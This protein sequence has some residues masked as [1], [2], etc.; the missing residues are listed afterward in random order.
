MTTMQKIIKYLALAFAIFLCVNIIGGICGALFSFSFFFGGRDVAGEMQEYYIEDNIDILKVDLSAIDFHIKSGDKFKLETN[1]KYINYNTN[2]NVL[3]IEETK[4]FFAVFPKGVELTVYVP[5]GKDF[6]YVYINTGAGRVDIDT[7]NANTLDFD[8]GAGE[9]TARRIEA[10]TKADIDGGAGSITISSGK[11]NNLN[12]E[13]GV[14]ELNLTSRLTG[15]CDL[16]YGIGETNLVL[17][18]ERNDYKIEYDG[19]VGEARLEGTKMQ[20]DSVYGSG[21]NRIEIDG[22]VGELNITFISDLEGT[23]TA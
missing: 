21:S 15:N 16:D 2:D 17:I 1:H 12:I 22:G 11:I 23:F 6:E 8:L 9:M 3:E 7:L 13:M 18:G 4:K 20:D 19:G 5:E 14:G 10:Y